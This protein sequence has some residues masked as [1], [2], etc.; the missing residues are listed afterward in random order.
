MPPDE[1]NFNKGP[2]IWKG[3]DPRVLE[4]SSLLLRQTAVQDLFVGY[5]FDMNNEVSLQTTQPIGDLKLNSQ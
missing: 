4:Q 3:E 1:E 5:A 2:I